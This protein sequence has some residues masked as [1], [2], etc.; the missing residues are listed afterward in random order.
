LLIDGTLLQA[1]EVAP[2]T[3]DV[4]HSDVV[5]ISHGHFSRV[6]IARWCALRLQAGYH[7]A[8]DAGGLAVLGYQHSTLK[9]PCKSLRTRGD[10][11]SDGLL[12]ALLGLNW[13]TE[14]GL[15][16]PIKE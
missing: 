14:E 7:F 16:N 4:D 3:E 9:E 2:T 10:Q 12:A 15:N 8:A 1:A 6:F 5:L 11:I 13:Y